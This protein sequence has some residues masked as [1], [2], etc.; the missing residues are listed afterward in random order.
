MMFVKKAWPMALL[1]IGSLIVANGCKHE[2]KEGIEFEI[3]EAGRK[4]EGFTWYKFSPAKLASSGLS[5]HTEPDQRTRFNN[6]AATMLDASGKVMEGISF[7]EE[8]LIVKELYKSNGNLSS[9]AM[10]LKRPSAPEADAD[11]WVWGYFDEKGSV[12]APASEK[13]SQ[14]RGCH[15]QNGSIDFSLMNVAHP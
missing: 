1:L 8:S 11:G 9:Y 15:N 13:G 7:P 6:I 4:A 12:R 14:C 5:G 10:M 2:A 3:F